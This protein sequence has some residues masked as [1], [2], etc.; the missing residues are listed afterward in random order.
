[1]CKG[2]AVAADSEGWEAGG[3][4]GGGSVARRRGEGSAGWR[5]SGKAKPSDS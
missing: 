4:G 2:R 1:L 5:E 3:G